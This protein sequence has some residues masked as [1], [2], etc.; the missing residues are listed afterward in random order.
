MSDIFVSYASEDRL[1]V[2]LIVDALVTRGWSVWWDKS[3]QPGAVWD[4][5]IGSEMETA[6]CVVV[7]WSRRSVDSAWVRSEAHEARQRNILVPLLLDPVRIPLGLSAIQAAN[8]VDW[9]GDASDPEFDKLTSS[10]AEVLSRTPAS[11]PSTP[12]TARDQAGKMLANAV[13]MRTRHMIVAFS[14]LLLVFAAI[15]LWDIAALH[16]IASDAA[17]I[18]LKHIEQAKY[19]SGENDRLGSNIRNARTIKIL[20][21]NANSFAQT[22]RVDLETFFNRP[23]ASM[24]VILATADSEFYR[25]MTPMTFDKWGANE[26]ASETNMDLI[27]YSRKRLVETAKD[28]SKIEFKYFNT[29]FRLPLII[30]DDK[31]CYLT[32][33]L[34]PNE[35]DQ[36]P[37]LEFDGGY[38]QSCTRHFNR[39]W[40]LSKSRIKESR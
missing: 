8:L 4:E 2:K 22:F 35:G 37:R 1:R 19:S 40:Q 24:Q 17:N 30:I 27:D 15:L 29:Q 26:P 36:S 7:L 25:D 14:G 18:G 10:I 16:P 21:L 20:A 34:P 28:E 5:V 32:I 39:L 33:R 38:A 13:R 6:R 11:S 31:Y 9:K 3:I 12:R 23:D